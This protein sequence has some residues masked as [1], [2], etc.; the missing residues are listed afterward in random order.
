MKLY[1]INQAMLDLVD[2]ETGEIL[3]LDAFDALE[4]QRDEKIENMA[5]WIKDLRAESDA[6]KA[7]ELAL[8]SRRKA[9]E[10][11]IERLKEYLKY[12]LNGEKFKTAKVAISYRSTPVVKFDDEDGF[13]QW[14]ERNGDQYLRYSEP[15]IN[16]VEVKRALDAG[17]ELPGAHIVSNVSTLIR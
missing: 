12:I 2:S 7:E 10:R 17:E 9:S 13:K 8:A 15:E 6:I 16:K 4:M 11:K 5:L 1:E 14:A 3:D